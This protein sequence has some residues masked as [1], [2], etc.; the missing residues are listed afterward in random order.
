MGNQGRGKAGWGLCALLL[1]I[2]RWW[3]QQLQP[4]TQHLVLAIRS[5]CYSPHRA[6]ERSAADQV[7]AAGELFPRV[8]VGL[9]VQTRGIGGPARE[10]GAQGR[11]AAARDAPAG[12]STPGGPRALRSR[13][14][15][16]RSFPGLLALL[17]R[18]QASASPAWRPASCEPASPHCLSSPGQRGRL[19]RPAGRTASGGAGPE[20][21]RSSGVQSA[22]AEAVHPRRRGQD[23]GCFREGS[24]R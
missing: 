6:E 23:E 4:T 14:R 5:N 9:G 20:P 22:A 19:R 15:L 3:P 11:V 10:R 1:R 21:G 13:P 2:D 12:S 17:R 7:P 24:L 8:G 18:L 16:V